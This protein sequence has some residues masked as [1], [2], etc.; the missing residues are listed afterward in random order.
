MSRILTYVRKPNERNG[1]KRGMSQCVCSN[2]ETRTPLCL[3]WNTCPGRTAGAGFP[4]LPFVWGGLAAD[5]SIYKS[6]IGSDALFKGGAPASW[7]SS[8]HLPKPPLGN[9]ETTPFGAWG[10]LAMGPGPC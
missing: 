4:L 7:S 9:Q 8:Q 5:H 2:P 3:Q 10:S 1:K 6:M